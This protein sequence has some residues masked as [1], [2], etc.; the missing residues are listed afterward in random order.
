M[1]R[2]KIKFPDGIPL[3]ETDI[4]VR[5]GDI[6]YGGHMGNDAYLAMMHEARMRW[7]GRHGFDE[8]N[9]GGISLIMADSAIAYKAEAFYGDVLKIALYATGI[10]DRSFD[11]L[12]HI[13][14]VR[15]NV[16][17]DIAHAKTGMLC[18]DYTTRR[19]AVMTE[20]FKNLFPA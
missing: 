4:P 12:Y 11:L 1:D 3:F 2:V 18:F 7:L 17:K 5:I 15:D 8:L 14:A 16:R 19:I 6:N 10:T 13:S 20:P 9:A